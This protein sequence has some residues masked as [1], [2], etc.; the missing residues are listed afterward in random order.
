MIC[1]VHKYTFIHLVN[2]QNRERQL[3]LEAMRSHLALHP[4][5][6]YCNTLVFFY[7]VFLAEMLH[8]LNIN[9]DSRLEVNSYSS[10]TN[11]LLYTPKTV[12]CM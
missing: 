2:R 8:N 11:Y 3:H 6:Q 9:K 1:A 7:G 4:I 10:T 12:C 5:P